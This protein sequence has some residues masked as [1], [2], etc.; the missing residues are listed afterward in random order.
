MKKKIKK[1]FEIKIINKLLTKQMELNELICKEIFADL[2]FIENFN[3]LKVK[4]FNSGIEQHYCT[5]LTP[6]KVNTDIE[7][8][9]KQKNE[10][11]HLKWQKEKERKRKPKDEMFKLKKRLFVQKE[12]I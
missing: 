2:V 7:I 4:A 10:E 5:F 8:K 9:Y 3:D 12:E 6:Q 1:K 11:F